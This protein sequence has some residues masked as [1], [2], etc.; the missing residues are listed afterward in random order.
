MKKIKLVDENLVGQEGLSR[1]LKP[2]VSWSKDSE[3]ADIVIYTDRLCHIHDVDKSKINCAWII[4]P[5]IIN[6]ENYVNL[7]KNNTKFNYVFTYIKNIQEQIPDSFFVPHGGTWLKSEEI[8]L[9]EKTK[10]VSSIFSGKDWN[11]YHKMRHR[12]YQRLKDSQKVDFYGS[13]CGN[14]IDFKIDGLKDYMFSIV[15]ENSIESDYFTEK[16]LDCFLTGTIPIYCGSGSISKYFEIDGVISFNGDEDL[17]NILETLSS[18][19]YF[20]KIQN[21]KNNFELAKKYI[22]PEEIIQNFL[23]EK[24][25]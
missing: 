7:L 2:N 17:P 16:L 24:V 15:V 8:F 10:M 13:G 5:P 18:E 9:H 19:F 14:P 22:H 6:G 20:S 3:D 25:Q 23:D 11:P 4:E 12:I 21:I 1:Y